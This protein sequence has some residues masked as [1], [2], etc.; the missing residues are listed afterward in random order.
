[1]AF[2]QSSSSTEP[3]GTSPLLPPSATPNIRMLPLFNT[4][5]TS[6]P[7]MGCFIARSTETELLS[8][9]WMV[10]SNTTK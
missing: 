8:S 7:K 5:T 2:C 10:P 3:P 4:L 1:M 9:S 6:I